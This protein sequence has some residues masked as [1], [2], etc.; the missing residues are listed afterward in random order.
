MVHSRAWDISNDKYTGHGEVHSW[1]PT[2]EAGASDRRGMFRL[3][4]GAN[5]ASIVN[6]SLTHPRNL[7]QSHQ[8]GPSRLLAWFDSSD[9]DLEMLEDEALQG[10]RAGQAGVAGEC[11]E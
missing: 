5:L 11:R 7:T 6:S 9:E 3:G 1:S 10:L 2:S 4:C 8:L